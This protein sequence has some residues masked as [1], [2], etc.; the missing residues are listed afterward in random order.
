M[1]CITIL[2]VLMTLPS[3]LLAQAA[4]APS[5][6]SHRTYSVTAGVGNSLG[7]FGAQGERYFADERV[8]LFLGMGYTPSVDAGY[9]T[10]PTFA[11]G[12]RTFTNGVKHRVFVEG[13]L[14][15]LLVESTLGGNSRYYGPGLQAGYQ[16][17]SGGGFT[18]MASAGAGR[19]LG[20]AHG[21]DPWAM[22]VGLSLGYT[23][24]RAPDAG[25]SSDRR[26][27]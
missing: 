25:G 1:R 6:D 27:K 18:L 7:W 17:V 24:R 8:S 4:P 23:W 16:F 2:P 14:S 10:G 13:S 5:L 12:I 9:A 21:I 3:L 15:Q 22:Q 11:G 19:A 20:I 26:T